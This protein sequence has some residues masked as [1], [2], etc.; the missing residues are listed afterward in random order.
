MFSP[1]RAMG[2]AFACSGAVAARL[3]FVACTS[4]NGRP[5]A[6][7]DCVSSNAACVTP[8]IGG[9]SGSSGEGGA[10]GC[11]VD[12]SASQCTQ[13]ANSACCAPLAACFASTD[14]QNLL[15]CETTC[16]GASAC[17]TACKQQ[18]PSSVLALSAL[19]SC[20]NSKCPICRQSGVGDPC[21]EQDNTCIAGVSCEGSWCTRTCTHDA[22]CTGIG[23]SG[24]NA[25]G[26]EN[27]CIHSSSS[28][29]LCFPGC[30]VNSDCALFPTTYCFA[31]TSVDGLVATICMSSP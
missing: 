4:D 27:A 14:C 6:L 18:Y 11:A 30:S 19:D 15:N 28:G 25:L 24:G 20:L 7:G 9:G 2:K 12:T 21:V 23:P 5:A 1:V 22:N 10:G 26:R 29:D 3:L 31:T 8:V 13:C 17:V 16:A